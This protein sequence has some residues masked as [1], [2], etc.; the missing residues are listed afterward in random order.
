MST[1]ASPRSAAQTASVPRPTACA[2]PLR[3]PAL[4]VSIDT[5]EEFDW[6]R[7]AAAQ[8]PRVTHTAELERLQDL[9][10]DVGVRPTYV[11]DYPLLTDA[12]TVD[13]LRRLQQRGTCE[14]GGHLHP[15]VNP[16]VV[17]TDHPRNTYLCNL[18]LS[19]QEEKLGRLNEAFTSA[20]DCQPTCFKAGRYG[21]S[22]ETAQL[23]LRFG[24]RVDCSA[25]AYTS[26]TDDDG[27]DFRHITNKPFYWENQG[28]LEVPCSVAY[29]R[30]SQDWSHALHQRLS[31]DPWR[32]MR[33]IGVLWHTR[34]L[35]KIFLS[36]EVHQG[37][38]LKLAMSALVASAAPVLHLSFHSPS[39]APGHT[40]YVRDIAQRDAFLATIRDVLTYA[41]RELGAT[42]YTLSEFAALFSGTTP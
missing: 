35:R 20:L 12:P 24:Y 6:D 10:D 26:F 30:F 23:L 18:P 2:A 21:L 41:R 28:L 3:C 36:P 17:E 16:P 22:P 39:L 7:P 29:S 38:N 5:E 1:I 8:V 27:P 37:A 32:A 14:I 19:L 42:S 25:V 34:L 11:V 4:L 15:W 40:P 9:C 31:S 13:V 33:M